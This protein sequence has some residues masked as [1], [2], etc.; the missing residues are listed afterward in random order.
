[1]EER[2]VATG[3]NLVDRGGVEVD[4]DGT[5]H[6]FAAAG[7]GEEGIVGACVA[8]ITDVGVGA[9]VVAK[10]VLEE[11]AGGGAYGSAVRFRRVTSGGEGR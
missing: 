9:A 4:E 7:L 5:G 10:A 1:M 6:V 8:N 3:A 2:A 11:V